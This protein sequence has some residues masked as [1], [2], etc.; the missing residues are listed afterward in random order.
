M[1]RWNKAG[2]V[3]ATGVVIRFVEKNG[4]IHQIF[5]GIEH[6]TDGNTLTLSSTNW[7]LL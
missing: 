6:V 5:R 4:L 2:Y 1:F 7:L 3:H